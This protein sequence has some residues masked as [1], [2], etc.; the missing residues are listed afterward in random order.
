MIYTVFDCETSGLIKEKEPL[1][2][3]LEFGYI[4]IN[5]YLEILRGGSFYFYRPIWNIPQS[6]LDVNGLTLDFLKEHQSEYYSSM[7]KLWAILQNG[8]LIGK[9]SDRF[10][11][12]ICRNMFAICEDFYSLPHISS[13]I[14]MQDVYG[15][16]F[17]DVMYKETGQKLRRPGKLEEYMTIAGLSMNQVNK[18]FTELF[19]DENRCSA[20]GALFDTYMTYLTAKDA[21]KRG[22]LKLEV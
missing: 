17:R 9:N 13:S 16:V 18:E 15:P 22:V 5:E 20:H 3:V 10:D 14:D 1:P 7:V 4:Q 12:P 11:I 19:P 2:V 21:V 6:A 8:N